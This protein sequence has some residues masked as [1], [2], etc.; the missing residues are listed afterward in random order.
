M[1]GFIL[2]AFEMMPKHLLEKQESPD[3]KQKIPK[4]IDKSNNSATEQIQRQIKTENMDS[5][6]CNEVEIKQEVLDEK[7][8]TPKLR[9]LIKNDGE[10]FTSSIASDID[11]EGE[12]N[13]RNDISDDDSSKSQT[14]SSQNNTYSNVFCNTVVKQEPIDVEMNSE[15]E[16][17]ENNKPFQR[18]FSSD[19]SQMACDSD[20][21]VSSSQ[22]TISSSGSGLDSIPVNSSH[23][24][25][26]NRS[27]SLSS[28]GAHNSPS[29]NSSV[30]SPSNNISNISDDSIHD[31]N[32][33]MSESIQAVKALNESDDLEQ[34]FY[35]DGYSS[36]SETYSSG[37]MYESHPDLVSDNNRESS[38]SN[39]NNITDISDSSQQSDNQN[40]EDHVVTS[41]S[42]NIQ[43]PVDNLTSI[44]QASLGQYE[45]ISSPEAEH[46][47]SFSNFKVDSSYSV[48]IGDQ[49]LGYSVP[50]E[51]NIK[52]EPNYSQSRTHMSQKKDVHVVDVDNIS[53]EEEEESDR[54]SDPQNELMQSA[55][56]SILSLTQ[57]TPPS[58]PSTSYSYDQSSRYSDSHPGYDSQSEDKMFGNELKTDDIS[59]EEIPMED[60]LD[61]AVNSILF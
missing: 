44:A 15:G 18:Y 34:N 56:N 29:H 48:N 1:F 27:N 55:I 30:V 31:D 40:Y 54:E 10:N 41:L 39:Q 61:A 7:P 12:G 45:P 17:W 19:D 33:D 50:M 43:V 52:L 25:F 24:R 16:K 11:T 5:Q 58:H 4:L 28:N 53:E 26:I 21:F 42:E 22:Q 38:F 13:H 49:K 35:L 59:E 2:D 3:S 57:D 20:I 32:D 6:F 23:D 8:A 60:D 51:T 37:M 9:L 46:E 47:E 14:D 36:K